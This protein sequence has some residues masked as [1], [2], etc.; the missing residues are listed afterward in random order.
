MTENISSHPSAGE[1]SPQSEAGSS[2][3]GLIDHTLLK[4]DATTDQIRQLCKEAQEYR[5]ASV[6]VNSTHVRL[7]A[8]L[9]QDSPV[10]ICTVVGFPLGA[11]M[12]QVKAFEAELAIANGAREVD[13]VQNIGA[14]KAKEYDLVKQDIQ[15]VVWVCHAAGVLV[16]VILET[17]QLTA[18][19]IET[20]CRLSKEAGADFVKT[21]TGFVGGGATVQNIALMRKV[22]GPQIGVK[23]SGGIR[24]LADAQK[25]VEAGANRIG[26]S[27]GVTIV[28]EE[29]GILAASKASGPK[30]GEGY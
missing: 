9:L 1:A 25:M 11:N 18:E 7:C 4:P 16:K 20:A 24:T 6:C 23:A 22:V 19:E 8:E 21:S 17:S 30:G 2:L 28:Q 12:S 3:A 27:A 5:F 13:M 26:A 10:K 15:A 14:L 29:Q